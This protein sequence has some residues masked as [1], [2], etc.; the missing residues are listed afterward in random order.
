MNSN[1]PPRWSTS[2]VSYVPCSL[3]ILPQ[4]SLALSRSRALMS[5]TLNEHQRHSSRCL[6]WGSTSDGTCVDFARS[7]LFRFP[8]CLSSL[9]GWSSS[10]I[11]RRSVVI[12]LRCS[13]VP[14]VAALRYGSWGMTGLAFSR[15]QRSSRA[16]FIDWSLSLFP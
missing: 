9:E 6:V 5:S 10:S 11:C 14:T 15:P 16:V 4:L 13:L 7:R 1:P 2:G 8:I 3:V 12:H